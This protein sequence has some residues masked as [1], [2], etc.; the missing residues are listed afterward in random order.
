MKKPSLFVLILIL[1]SSSAQAEFYSGSKLY[2]FLE[3]DM[4]G[5]SDFEAGVS[6]GYVLGVYDSLAGILVC[7]PEGVTVRQ[8]KQ[9]VFNYMQQHPES[10]DKSA[11]FSVIA[12]V[13]EVWPCK[14]K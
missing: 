4:R 12:A 11:D 7:S 10:W 13:R 3:R 8:V 5:A 1:F 6:T 2:G 14:K 9:I